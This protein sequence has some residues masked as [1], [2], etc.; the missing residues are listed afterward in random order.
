MP[1]RPDA[2]GVDPC[3]RATIAE[4]LDAR[5]D[6][7]LDALHGRVHDLSGKFQQ[8][9]DWVE[10]I[11]NR[12]RRIELLL[13]RT[14]I[15]KF[16]DIDK[17]IDGIVENSQCVVETCS[18]LASSG[19]HV[20]ADP[21]CQ[22]VYNL[23]AFCNSDS[24]VEPS[25]DNLFTTAREL[26]LPEAD[27]V[28]SGEAQEGEASAAA[29]D[30]STA[31]P[32]ASLRSLDASAPAPAGPSR[33]ARSSRED[34]AGTAKSRQVDASSTIS[35][36]ASLQSR[37]ESL[38]TTMLRSER[39]RQGYED[40][41]VHRHSDED[42]FPEMFQWST[43]PLMADPSW[44]EPTPRDLDLSLGTSI[45]PTASS[46]SC[47]WDV[48]PCLFSQTSLAHAG[49]GGADRTPSP[50]RHHDAA[51]TSLDG[52]GRMFAHLIAENAKLHAELQ[53]QSEGSVFT[54]NRGGLGPCQQP[55]STHAVRC[56]ASSAL[57]IRPEV[58][59]QPVSP[60]ALQQPK[61]KL[62]KPSKKERERRQKR[63]VT[64]CDNLA[65][66]GPS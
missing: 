32:S 30:L 25:T 64:I 2:G 22:D 54:S 16:V 8:A 61:V 53:A 7:A 48:E 13:F 26:P 17:V 19:K 3:A 20:A 9:E 60:D 29:V 47:V 11:A 66:C 56:P 43:Q 15:S 65:A 58:D 14:P 18:D 55:D 6:K 37:V 59:V 21:F 62:R 40:E 4:G 31:A 57:V 36:C 45:F 52:K 12:V 51:E 35:T 41:C 63:G 44:T 10:E 24:L 42:T 49:P 39:C 27:A 34:A 23:R 28:A 1:N 46:A 50:E 38:Q 33:V 5:H